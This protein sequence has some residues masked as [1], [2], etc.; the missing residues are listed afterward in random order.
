MALELFKPTL[1]SRQFIANMDRV[2]VFKNI[3]DTKYQGELSFGQALKI[4]E[5]GDIDVSDYSATGGVTW[6]DIDDAG[7][8]L[9]VDQKKYFAFAVDDVD[10]AQMN[11]DVMNGAMA[12]SS[13]TVSNTIDAYIAGKYTE[14]G[15]SVSNMG[16]SGTDLDIYAA[17]GGHDGV[18]GVISNM[19]LYMNRGD[20]P[21]DGRWAVVDP[22]FAAYMKYASLVDN[23]DG[24]I[25]Q[26]PDG[27]FVPGYIGSIY[28]INFFMSNNV[29]NDGTTYRIMF[30][31]SDALAYVGQLSKIEAVRRE[32]YFSDGMRGLYIYGAKVVRPDHLGVAYLAYAGYS[33]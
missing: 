25:K 9:V 1:W 22:N 14:A 6:Q 33:S 12:K 5:I 13:H 19:N 7:R 31:S 2:H 10:K 8:T 17:S 29:S 16:T 20:V 3:V 21:A 30:G 32:D 4:N 18:L 15:L 23:I 24:G 27:R 11:V 26:M 28:G